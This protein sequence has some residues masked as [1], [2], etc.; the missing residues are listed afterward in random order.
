MI[1]VTA[2]TCDGTFFALCIQAGLSWLEVHRDAVNAMNVFPVPDG[3]TGTN[4]WHTLQSGMSAVMAAPSEHIGQVSDTLARGALRG[5]RGNSGTIL[6]M[7]LR[8]FADALAGQPDMDAAL[9]REACDN[10]VKYAYATVSSVMSPV[11]GTILTVARV[12]AE[13]LH[14]E[15]EGT[16]DLRHLTEHLLHHAQI[17]LEDT[18]NQLPVLKAA[19]VVD[20][21]GYG[22]VTIMDGVVRFLDG[23]SITTSISAQPTPVAQNWQQALVPEDEQGY[24]YDVQFLMLGDALDVQKVRQDISAM[25]WSPLIDGDNTL[26]K[27][28]IHV[29][30]PADPIGYAITQGAQLDDI[31]VENMQK[32]YL[33][34]VAQREQREVPT[35]L[36]DDIGVITVA[37]GDGLAEILTQYGAASVIHGGQT[38]NPSVD[39]FVNAIRVLPHK[40]I[41][42]LPN[43]GNVILTANQV[44]PLMPERNIVVVGSKTI[45]QGMSALLAYWDRREGMPLDETST[46]MKRVLG[47]VKTLEVTTASRDVRESNI[48]KGE[49]LGL[50]NDVPKVSG[51]DLQDVLLRLLHAADV[52]SNEL[53]S[54]YWGADINEHEAKAM[55]LAVQQTFPAQT[56]ELLHGGQPLYPYIVSV[57]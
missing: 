26:I 16:Q 30:N 52:E 25:G 9:F 29:H 55:Q 44:A 20:S 22:L 3:D 14:A 51:T 10:A 32:Q 50:L 42:L 53:V 38:M 54:M 43:N 41:I 24:G 19:N 36:T 37:A 47:N 7:L 57:E 4:M 15:D 39:D 8:G 40:N 48:Q 12:A 2:T 46:L 17:A 11:E 34:Y 35:T 18:P 45:P 56:V 31:V 27:V 28:H 5:A 13:R 21:G 49:W 23:E 6:S 33:A 1:A